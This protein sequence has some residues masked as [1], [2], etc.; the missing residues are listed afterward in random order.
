MAGG[1][2]R[3]LEPERETGDSDED[4]RSHAEVTSPGLAGRRQQSSV[5]GP[6][7]HGFQLESSSFKSLTGRRTA[8]FSEQVSSSHWPSLILRLEKFKS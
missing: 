8:N 3:G 1:E 5:P 7:G 6:T 2:G 4:V